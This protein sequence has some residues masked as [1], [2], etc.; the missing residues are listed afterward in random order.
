MSLD[1][2]GIKQELSYA[3]V[4]AVASRCGFTLV[5]PPSDVDSIDVEIHGKGRLDPASKILSPSVHLQ[6]KATVVEAP[7]PKSRADKGNASGNGVP[8]D[9]YAFPLEIKNYNELRGNRLTPRLL[10]VLFLP[11]KDGHWLSHSEKGLTAR[12]CAY[13]CSL[14]DLPDVPNE[15]KKTV[16]VP[17]ANVFNCASL[18]NIMIGISKGAPP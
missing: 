14:R 9:A 1:E 13:W 2:N 3:Y 7:K 15:T 12:R 6:L 5:R 16:Y 18:K 17:K 8:D 11:V 4:H 10:V